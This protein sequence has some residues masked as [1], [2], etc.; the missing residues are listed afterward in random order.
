MRPDTSAAQLLLAHRSPRSHATPASPL[1]RTGGSRYAGDASSDERTAPPR[2]RSR[3]SPGHLSDGVGEVST[4]Q[5]RSTAA[6]LLQLQAQLQQ[7]GQLPPLPLAV[8]QLAAA[9]RAPPVPA[10]V[11]EEGVERPR[12]AAASGAAAMMAAVAAAAREDD[13]DQQSSGGRRPGGGYARPVIRATPLPQPV[14]APSPRSASAQPAWA[15]AQI[16]ALSPQPPAQQPLVG[17]LQPILG[18]QQPASGLRQPHAPAV[19]VELVASVL[20]LQQ[21]VAALEQQ[22]S[23]L[24]AAQPQ[25]AQPPPAPGISAMVAHLLHDAAGRMGGGSAAEPPPHQQPVP[26]PE[27]QQVQDGAAPAHVLADLLSLLGGVQQQ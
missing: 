14:G 3:L 11:K 27:P 4:V 20:S 7:A 16:A 8:Q 9:G 13:H 15:P 12:R 24:R 21:R 10:T 2:Q 22:V 25:A 19:V 26:T 6:E 17:L 18:P 5:E 23:D 1:P